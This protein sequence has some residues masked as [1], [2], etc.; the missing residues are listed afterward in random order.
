MKHPF[1][2]Q[3]VHAAMVDVS[4]A[5]EEGK[6]AVYIIRLAVMR[7]WDSAVARGAVE[8]TYSAPGW[9]QHVDAYIIKLPEDK[10]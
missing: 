4:D 7:V 1:T 9:K 8:E 2:E 6:F 3:D 10:P 5:M